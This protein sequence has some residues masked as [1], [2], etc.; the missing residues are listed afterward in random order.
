MNIS[1]NHHGSN[2]GWVI[3]S[4]TYPQRRPRGS[5][6]RR[7]R[8]AG[9]IRALS[10]DGRWGQSSRFLDACR[11]SALRWSAG[12]R[13]GAGPGGLFTLPRRW[14]KNST[15]GRWADEHA[16]SWLAI[17]IPLSLDCAIVL[18]SGV[19]QFHADPISSREA[20]RAD[21]PDGALSPVGQGDNRARGNFPA[22]HRE[23]KDR[24]PTMDIRRWP[25]VR[26]ECCEVTEGG[27]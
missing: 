2:I 25:R 14:L 9:G 24:R 21:E 19:C 11:D 26:N 23:C 6:R 27:D 18:S 3:G 17:K 10:F 13:I 16:K 15:N 5:S 20:G 12:S 7:R 8:C 22:R 4:N 1:Q